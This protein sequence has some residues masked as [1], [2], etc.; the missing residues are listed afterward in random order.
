MSEDPYDKFVEE[1]VTNTDQEGE[2]VTPDLAKQ[3]GIGALPAEAANPEPCP[4]SG[5]ENHRDDDHNLHKTRKMA[6]KDGELVLM[7]HMK[8]SCG[9]EKQNYIG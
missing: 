2:V 4:H 7:L 6:L 9:F 1:A 8:C 3:S 5:P